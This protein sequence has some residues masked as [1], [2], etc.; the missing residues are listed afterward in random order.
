MHGDIVDLELH[1]KNYL[2]TLQSVMV[3]EQLQYEIKDNINRIIDGFVAQNR[4]ERNE[5]DTQISFDKKNQH[6]NLQINEKPV[7]SSQYPIVK[8]EN[9]DYIT[10]LKQSILEEYPQFT[11]GEIKHIGNIISNAFRYVN[12]SCIDNWRC[13]DDSIVENFK[14]ND[15][16]NNGCCGFYDKTIELNSGRKFKFGFNYG[17]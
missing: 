16:K 17:H 3:H 1:I 13:S 5:F 9:P 8:I 11:P 12:D 4:L 2:E 6:L 14:Y 7:E 10:S 15:A